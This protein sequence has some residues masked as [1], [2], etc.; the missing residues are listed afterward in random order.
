MASPKTIREGV[1][2]RLRTIQGLTVY[3]RWPDQLAQ[4]PCAVMLPPESDYEQAFGRGEL[5][6]WRMDIHL[7][8][9]VK[10]GLDRGQDVLDRLL[11]TS[12]TGGVFGAIHGDRTLGGA[13]H[14]TS[15]KG[16]RSYDLSETDDVAYAAA[17]VETEVW[18][19]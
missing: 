19:S 3:D 15:I 5:T 2:N 6:L 16:H 8:A 14:W 18:A 4:T 10:A 9:S 1:A 17:V 7:F 11:A 12:S 13:A